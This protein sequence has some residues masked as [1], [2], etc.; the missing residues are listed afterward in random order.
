MMRHEE[1]F[2]QGIRNTRIYHQ[3]WLPDGEVRAVLLIVHGLG[4]HSGRYMNLVNHFIPLGYAVYALDHLGHGHSEGMRKHIERFE[5]FTDTLKVYFDSVQQRQPGKQVVLVGH[6]MGELIGAFY[7]LDHQTELAGAVLSGTIAKV[8][9][10]TSPATVAFGKMLAGIAPRLRFLG[11]EIP[12]ICRDPSVV[13]AYV[14]DPLV[15]CGKATVRLAT[16]LLR[17][18]LHVQARAAAIRLPIL[19]LQGSADRIVD[20]AG[21]RMLYDAVSSEDK[22]LKIYDG[23][24]HEVYNEPERATV[25][26]DVETWLESRV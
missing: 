3:C 6:S 19:I 23:F 22:T 16:E 9:A 10:N 20:P 14:D 12:G 11:L 15:Y 17:A 13:Q 5:D 25:L 21:A 18:T 8:P 4:E 1:G 26:H 24:Y 2:F 7:L